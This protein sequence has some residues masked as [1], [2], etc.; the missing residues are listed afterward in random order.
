MDVRW[1]FSEP[2]IQDHIKLVLIVWMVG[3]VSGPIERYVGWIINLYRGLW[4]ID[5][6]I[7]KLV[8]V[9][10][11]MIVREGKVDLRERN[12]LCIRSMLSECLTLLFRSVRLSF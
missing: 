2:D 1:K 12:S 9:Q 3:T 6:K 11:L 4:A 7:K 8:N 10:V 5:A